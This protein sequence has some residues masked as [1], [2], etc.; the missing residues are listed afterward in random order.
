[1]RQHVREAA[2]KQR[3]QEEWRAKQKYCNLYIENLDPSIDDE[4]LNKEFAR[5]G[6][7]TSAKVMKDHLGQ[8]KGY[9]FVCYDAEDAARQAIDEMDGSIL[10]ANSIY[11]SFAQRKEERQRLPRQNSAMRTASSHAAPLFVPSDSSSA[12]RATR[13]GST[14]SYPSATPIPYGRSEIEKKLLISHVSPNRSN[15]FRPNS[16]AAGANIESTNNVSS[17]H[18][19]CQCCSI[20]HLSAWC[21]CVYQYGSKV[22]YCSKTIDLTNFYTDHQA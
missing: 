21:I 8:S 9:G 20:S 17:S 22:P 18:G 14:P 19:S 2:R 11:V 3:R 10:M 4:Q 13:S 6:L 7:I 16:C 15:E 1:M 12:A 5:F